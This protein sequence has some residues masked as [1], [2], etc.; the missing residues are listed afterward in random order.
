L[1][2]LVLAAILRS[3]LCAV[4]CLHFPQH[5]LTLQGFYGAAL[6]VTDHHS[7]NLN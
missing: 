3:P 6:T 2:A 5:S 1:A 4:N 7:K